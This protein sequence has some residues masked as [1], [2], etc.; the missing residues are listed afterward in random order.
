MESFR[1]TAAWLPYP[2]EQVFDLVADIE[3]YPEFVPGYI[4]ARILSRAGDRLEVEQAIGV[5]GFRERFVSEARLERPERISVRSREGL[6]ERLDIDWRFVDTGD[7][8]RVTLR[9]SYRLAS[10]LLQFTLAPVFDRMAEQTL[11][12][13]I[14]RSHAAKL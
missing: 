4:S 6:I 11:Q 3:R 5:G 10:R 2:R 12:A 1:E 9:M 8:C 13:F 7:G 14:R